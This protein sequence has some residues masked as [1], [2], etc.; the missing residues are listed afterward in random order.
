[1]QPIFKLS[2]MAFL[3]F[4]AGCSSSICT[5]GP[6][7]T[8]TGGG[9]GSGG[10]GGGGGSAGGSS[11]AGTMTTDGGNPLCAPLPSDADQLTVID[12]ADGDGVSD[13]TDNC[14][15]TSNR[16]QSDND[17]DGV[18]NACDNCAGMSNVD[19]LDTDA[20]GIGNRCDADMDGDAV[21]NA[22][23][24][25]QTIPNANQFHTLSNATLGDACNPDVDG[26]T[27]PNAMDNC[28]LVANSNQVIPTGATCT[29]DMDGDGVSESFDNCPLMS[30]STQ[31]DTDQDGIGDVCDHDIDDDSILNTADNCRS[32][33]NR[34]Q[35]D[36][37]GDGLGDACDPRE[38]FVVDPSNPSDC[39][40]LQLPFAAKGTSV[41]ISTGTRF[42]LPIFANRYNVAIHYQWQV[43]ARPAGANP[44]L[45]R[46]MGTV[47]QSRGVVYVYAPSVPASFY[48]DLPGSY[49]VQLSANIDSDSLYPSS[50]A[51][52]A[53]MLVVADGAAAPLTCP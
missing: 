34:A 14:L 25:C 39:L 20:D 17:L 21:I 28:P 1:M 53:Q 3:V 36:T 5:P 48:A 35:A 44:V 47:T 45:M 41:H 10:T 30:N 16:D 11:D 43:V 37:D 22:N 49:T 24:N 38:C 12:D 31:L 23:D 9:G 33:A 51:S 32:V 6:T 8:C 7:Q 19:Q 50:L 29:A 26:D 2:L 27:V 40:D 4:F 46:A 15:F 18:G 42:E 13:S 52:T